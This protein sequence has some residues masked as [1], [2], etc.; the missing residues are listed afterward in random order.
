[1]ADFIGMYEAFGFYKSEWFLKFM[2]ISEGS[3]DRLIFYT[4]DLPVNVYKAVSM[5]AVQ[6]SKN[7]EKWS[8]TDKFINM[9]IDDRIRF[10]CK[11][12]L[13]EMC[14]GNFI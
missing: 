5:T 3:G 8:L 11:A 9:K 14:T 7:L 6:A 1:M 2:G 4:K 10:M 13:T 12:G